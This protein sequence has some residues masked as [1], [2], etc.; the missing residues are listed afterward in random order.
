MNAE[1]RDYWHRAQTTIE[2][3]DTLTA[4]DPDSAVSRAYYAAFYAVSALFLLEDRAFTRHATLENAV[5]RDLVKAGRWD[6]GLG[7]AFSALLVLRDVGDYGGSHHATPEDARGAVE[8]AR[9][10]LS[11]VT[12]DAGERLVALGS[13]ENGK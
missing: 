4:S 9:R 13:R 3:A 5:H 11:A 7:A 10:I 2:T 12:R 6:V 1:V 8:N